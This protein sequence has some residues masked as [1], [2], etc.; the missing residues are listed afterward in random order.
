L[1][2]ST[3]TTHPVFGI[4]IPTSCPGVDAS[5][6][7]PRNT[8]VSKEEYDA[9][10]NQLASEFIKNFEKYADVASDEIKAAAPKVLVS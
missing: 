10:A 1:E 2:K 3:F 9:K 8:W 5:I 7:D 4:E 6:L